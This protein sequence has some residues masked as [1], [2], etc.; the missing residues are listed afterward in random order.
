MR[1]VSVAMSCCL[2]LAAATLSAQPPAPPASPPAGGA[3]V[4][5]ADESLQPGDRE[6]LTRA[7][8]LVRRWAAVQR[9]VQAVQAR[10]Q[11]PLTAERVQAIDQAWQ[12]GE[13]PE[14]LPAALAKNSG[15]QALQTLVAANLGFADA[16]ATDDQGAVVCMTQR[17][18]D[19]WQGDEETWTRAW[20][21]GNGAVVVSKV[22]P[23]AS[24]LDLVHIAV[25]IKAGG[26]MIGVLLVGR[27]AVGG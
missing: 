21:G 10:Q 5:F 2:V 12:R 17:T 8:Q 20:A 22:E 15:A 25:P 4:E 18:A 27:I 19:F 14:G 16:V 3:A 13:D 24:G 11:A 6:L 23:D 26:R 1:K 9:V 7:A